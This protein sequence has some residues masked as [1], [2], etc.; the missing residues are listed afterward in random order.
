MKIA[1]RTRNVMRG[2]VKRYGPSKM[3]MKLWDQEFAGTH[4]D[5]IDDTRGDCV[6]PHLEKHLKGGSIL[7]LGCGPGNSANELSLSSYS[8]YI[9]V[10]ISKEALAK[11]AKRTAENGRTA[12]N[13]FVCSDF[14][15]YQPEQKF[16]VILF[17]ESMY[18]IPLRKVEPILKHFS[19][20]LTDKGVFVVRMNM[21]DGKGGH[22]SRLG[23]MIEIV[24]TDFSVLE[25]RQ[26]GDSGPT[27]IV[28]RP[29]HPGQRNHATN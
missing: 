12:K 3:K 23:S 2:L 15:D 16:D 8:T 27:V 19:N 11:A 26:Y 13:S 4:W 20:H 28:F 5:F 6:Y 18:H 17:R 7:D 22:K 21:S 14:L 29:Q 24:E 25:K 1:E 10:D 9:G